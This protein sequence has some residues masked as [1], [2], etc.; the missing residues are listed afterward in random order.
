MAKLETLNFR[1]VFKRM[2]K[3]KY[4]KILADTLASENKFFA[5]SLTGLNEINF[6]NDNKN[7]FLRKIWTITNILKI[8]QD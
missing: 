5:D 2:Q 7:L 4:E 8:H 1:T 3:K 6:C